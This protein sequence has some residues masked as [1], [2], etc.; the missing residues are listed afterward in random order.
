ML[1]EPSHQ[2]L[3]SN[4]NIP[5]IQKELHL[6]QPSESDSETSNSSLK[7]N[8][9]SS[10]N[11]LIDDQDSIKKSISIGGIKVKEIPIKRNEIK[12]GEQEEKEEVE[13]DAIEMEDIIPIKKL[14]GSDSIQQIVKPLE[15]KCSLRSVHYDEQSSNHNNPTGIDSR[16]NLESYHQT[17]TM[18]SNLTTQQQQSSLFNSVAS[19]Q[20]PILE[21]G[22]SE[23]TTTSISK[24][25]G[26]G[27]RKKAII[28]VTPEQ[29]R[30]AAL[31]FHEE[32]SRDFDFWA[33]WGIG[34]CNIGY[35]PGKLSHSTF[36]V[37]KKTRKDCKEGKSLTSNILT[38][39]F[40][41][42]YFSG[43][44]NSVTIWWWKYVFYS[45]AY[46]W[47]IHV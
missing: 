14:R 32:L 39:F 6:I 41:S 20:R 17:L 42:R 24:S 25:T 18:N 4:L 34:V 16:A 37:I 47:F 28:K 7:T 44:S 1:L 29:K 8:L 45:L 19:S 27:W 22:I 15:A 2:S 5:P 12:G 46:S 11:N 35:L 31:G 33:S 38:S 36:T 3:P 30:L 10:N 21:R 13:T 23:T 40:R 26:S 43:N 9:N